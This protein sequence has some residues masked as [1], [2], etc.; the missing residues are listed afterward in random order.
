MDNELQIEE[1]KKFHQ[2]LTNQGKKV[3]VDNAA[4]IWI[5]ENAERWRNSHKRREN[6]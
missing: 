6:N 3:D 5:K 4:L 1:I 2:R